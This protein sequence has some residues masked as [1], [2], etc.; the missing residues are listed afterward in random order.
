MSLIP[1]KEKK[2]LPSKPAMCKARFSAFTTIQ[3]QALGGLSNMGIVN[4]GQQKVTATFQ[5]DDGLL[6]TVTWDYDLIGEKQA[7]KHGAMAQKVK[8]HPPTVKVGLK[9]VEEVPADVYREISV[10]IQ[11]GKKHT[12][13]EAKAEIETTEK[14]A[15]AAA[16]TTRF[17][18]GQIASVAKSISKMKGGGAPKVSKAIDQEN[19]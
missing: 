14:G 1:F 18:T 5:G 15:K 13:K 3:G 8:V 10:K 4:K 2:V 12:M 19:E 6:Y 16:G 9:T 11:Q 7:L 17:I